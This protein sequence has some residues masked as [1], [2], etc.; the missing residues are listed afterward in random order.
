MDLAEIYSCSV[1][2]VI[3]LAIDTLYFRLKPRKKN[4]NIFVCAFGAPKNGQFLVRYAEN[5]STF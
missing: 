1:S 5:V 2:T 3:A 4:A